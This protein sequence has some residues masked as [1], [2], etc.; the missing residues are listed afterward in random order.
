MFN[1]VTN[2]LSGIWDGYLYDSLL[3]DAKE[4]GLPFEDICRIES[5][6]DLIKEYVNINGESITLV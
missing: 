3:E 1:N 4:M 6:I 2:M 5:T